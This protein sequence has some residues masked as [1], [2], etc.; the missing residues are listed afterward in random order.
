[1]TLKKWRTEEKPQDIKPARNLTK[2]QK[3][4]YHKLN[5]LK[6]LPEREYSDVGD[7]SKA[8][9]LELTERFMTR[10]YS[11]KRYKRETSLSELHEQTRLN[12][13]IEQLKLKMNVK[14]TH[15]QCDESRKTILTDTLAW[16]QPVGERRKSK[17]KKK[18]KLTITSKQVGFHAI[19]AA[20]Q[21]CNAAFRN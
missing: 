20:A 13:I 16:L 7:Q 12:H 19:A 8:T 4:T 11:R 15:K 14:Q 18:F 2:V 3:K 10:E 1:M 6:D 17:S 21:R 5:F 9:L